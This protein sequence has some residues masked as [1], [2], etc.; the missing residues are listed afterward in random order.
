MLTTTR[1]LH[2]LLDG[3]LDGTEEWVNAVLAEAVPP[4]LEAAGYDSDTEWTV[5]GTEH[6]TIESITGLPK[7]QLT[8]AATLFTITVT[9]P[10]H[11]DASA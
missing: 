4:T 1:T 6:T 7:T 8:G 11:A 2:V 5:T 3:H 9:T 10:Q